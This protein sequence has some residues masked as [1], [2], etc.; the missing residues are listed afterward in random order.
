MEISGDISQGKFISPVR[1]FCE[2]DK[3]IHGKT[4]K[5]GKIWV[6]L[7]FLHVYVALVGSVTVANGQIE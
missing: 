7:S 3:I 2:K 5:N 4:V 6:F 1:Q